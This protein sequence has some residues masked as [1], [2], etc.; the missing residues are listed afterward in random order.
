MRMFAAI[1][2]GILILVLKSLS[3]EVLTQGEHT[4]IS[5]LRTVEVIASSTTD[6]AASAHEGTFTSLFDPP[7]LPRAAEIP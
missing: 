7:T 2:I 4:V 1:G 5:V 3:P 6:F